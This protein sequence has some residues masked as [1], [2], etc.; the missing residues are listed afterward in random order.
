MLN[1]SFRLRYRLL[2]GAFL[3]MF[4]AQ[5]Q[6]P[7]VAKVSA[8]RSNSTF[9]LGFYPTAAK[10]QS[11]Y[12]ATDLVGATAG[13]IQR[14]YFMYGST[15]IATGTTLS[16]LTIKLGQTTATG[17]AGGTTFFSDN[18]LTQVL[19][20]TSYTIAPGTSGDWFFI[21]L[22]T[23]FRY[24]PTQTVVLQITFTGSTATNFGTFGDNNNGKKL[25]AD[26]AGATTGSATS[27]TW[28][29][30]G[31]DVQPLGLPAPALA[32]TLLVYP[33]PAHETLGVQQTDVTPAPATIQ[34]LDAL[35]RSVRTVETSADA[36][37]VGTTLPLTDLPAGSYMVVVQNGDRRQLRR[38]TVE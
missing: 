12:L 4:G 13:N 35:G 2:L 17:F 37:R 23:P 34:V 19:F 29:H 32:T 18:S 6:A 14:L 31:F 27:S 36:L 20:N 7:Q 5:A 30:F 33:N 10:T 8:T 11:L 24:D 1:L 28:Q 38:I 25:Y 3:L 26:N 9:L 22:D 15:G 16:D 21:D